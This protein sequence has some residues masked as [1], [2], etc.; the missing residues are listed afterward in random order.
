MPLNKFKCEGFYPYDIVEM[1]PA[2]IFMLTFKANFQ[3]KKWTIIQE[4]V[5]SYII[6][7][8]WRKEN[9]LSMI[10]NIH[11]TVWCLVSIPYPH[12]QRKIAKKQAMQ[13]AL[14]N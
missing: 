10:L 2:E 3:S 12:Y 14:F 9:K 13:L 4:N 6:V 11:N 7:R 1:R 5:F 8:D